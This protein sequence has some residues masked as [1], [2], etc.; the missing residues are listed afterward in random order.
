MRKN[1][2]GTGGRTVRLLLSVS[3]VGTLGV[4]APP[5]PAS[6]AVV[7]NVT[8]TADGGAGS[9]RAAV[10]SA[11][12]ASEPA[13]IQLAAGASYA[14]TSCAATE[15]ANA[16]GDLDFTGSH[17][18]MIEG[19]GAT[20][21]QTCAGER[22]IHSLVGTGGLEIV[23]TTITGGTGTGGIAVFAGAS[24]TLESSTVT[25]ATGVST[26]PLVVP[27]PAAVTTFGNGS[28]AV[29]SSTISGTVFGAGITDKQTG[30]T[31][32]VTGSTIS[33]NGSATAVMELKAG[34]ILGASRELTITDS[35]VT[36]NNI[37]GIAFPPTYPNGPGLGSN[38]GGISMYV[39]G[40]NA[41]ALHGT[42]LTVTGNAGGSFG[43]IVAVPLELHDST[44]GNNWGRYVGGLVGGASM[45]LD[46][47]RVT[48]NHSATV[49]GG[50]DGAGTIDQSLITGNVGGAGLIQSGS[51]TITR[52]T[53]TGNDGGLVAYNSNPVSSQRVDLRLDHVTLVGNVTAQG[54]PI[55][56]ELIWSPDA[57][58]GS[59][60][61]EA[62]IVGDAGAVAPACVLLSIPN[63]SLGANVVGDSSCLAAPLATDA[64]GVPNELGPLADNGGPTLTRL[65][66]SRSVAIDRQPSSA[67]SC[68]GS[69]QR[70]VAR[71]QGAG[72]DS[73]AVE[74]VKAGYH[75]ITPSRI[76]DTRTGLGTTAL[77]LG[78]NETRTVAL[79]AIPGLPHPHVTAVVLNV[80]ADQPTAQ[81]HLTLS[82]AG[83][84][85]PGVSNLN[86]PPGRTIA[87]LATVA[88]GTGGDVVLRNN[89][90]DTGV[91]ID[92]AGWYD[93]GVIDPTV[94]VNCPC[95]NGFTPM[96][97]AR[98]LDTRPGS[99]IGG[100]AVPFGAGE[101]RTVAVG[102]VAGIPDDADAVVVHLTVTG[103]SAASHLVAFGG[104]A[105]APEA[106]NLNWLAGDTIANLAV[107]KLGPGGMLAL[108]N[109]AGTAD[110]IA[111]VTGW[112]STS[113]DG[114]RFTAAR[115]QRVL[116]TRAT[117]PAPT[118]FG[119]GESRSVSAAAPVGAGAVVLN[120]TGVLPTTTTHLTAWP[121]GVALPMASSLNLPAG[122]VRANAAVTG[123]SLGG[124]LNL[125][126]NSGVIDVVV[127]SVGYF[128]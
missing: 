75:P 52:S 77:P 46:R 120:V 15:D 111:D 63:T 70:G 105:P 56:H 13:T 59:L 30:G 55:D 9:L 128:S 97:P 89:S 54:R 91:I 115:P 99:T 65:P 29:T 95:G 18:V 76:F 126:N 7:F 104:G 41:R 84:P 107:V 39:P 19:A 10:D 37:S 85:D 47:V 45:T 5:I 64:V 61:V 6:A 25:G 4:L 82:P 102:G 73:G 106:S 35:S 33:G 109:S 49:A 60:D 121:A 58:Y 93:D 98:L 123:V 110:V 74:A 34:G 28:L 21:N 116:D 51:T 69:D 48:D 16:S 38:A 24:L 2:K 100:P 40:R 17:L 72:C 112:F 96:T 80:T 90:G 32:T 127:D 114:L 117:S 122:S 27:D 108:R 94:P 44:V 50:F 71:P 67:A 92:L 79:S 22:V 81:S 42:R 57:R 83:H 119:D 20:I 3:V 8:T 125:R 53:I 12:L 1:D 62:S 87:N 66:G 14:L 26:S 68:S 118:P 43:G 78:P 88:V 23:A 11:N 103:A 124:L 31:F 113:P 101:T 86:F 36:G